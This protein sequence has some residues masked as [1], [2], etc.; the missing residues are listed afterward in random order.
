MAYHY[1]Y[2]KRGKRKIKN[3]FKPRRGKES[4][5]L[6]TRRL[7]GI[8]GIILLLIAGVLIF[9]PVY[10]FLYEYI[11]PSGVRSGNVFTLLPELMLTEY[12]MVAVD[13]FYNEQQG[14]VTLTSGCKR[15]V[16]YVEPHQAESIY[17]GI[18]G[19]YAARPNGHDI[20][21]DTLQS[22]GIE[23]V[24][25]KVTELKDN[26]FYGRIILKQGNKIVSLDARPSDA[27]AI[28]VR[29]GAPI[30]VKYDLLESQ[31]EDICD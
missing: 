19:L 26:A 12:R 22:F 30:Y 13:V 20:A 25:V 23:V 28:A 7:K 3:P 17:R 18:K 4:P 27:T 2:S 14:V 24:M 16:A 5:R 9:I 8:K 1:D 6:K 29:V 11:A 10:F 15:I 21:V 31:G